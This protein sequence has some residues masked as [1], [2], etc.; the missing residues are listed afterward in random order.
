[1]KR[2]KKRDSFTDNQNT[3]KHRNG[4]RWKPYFYDKTKTK[5][6]QLMPRP[7]THAPITPK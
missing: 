5:N 7:K 2:E 4:V 1:M 6:D 3:K